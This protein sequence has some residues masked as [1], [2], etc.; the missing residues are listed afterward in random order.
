MKASADYNVIVIMLDSFRQDHIGFYNRGEPVFEGIEPCKTPNIDRFAQESVV[1]ENAYPSGLPTIPLR[2]ELMTGQDT[3]PFRPWQPLTREDIT[4][5]DILRREGY[6]CGL[7]SDTYHYRA[8]GMN[9]HRSFYAYRWMRGQE[10]DPYTSHPSERGVED[11]VNDNYP[12]IWRRRV[13]Q[14]LANTDDFEKEEDWFPAKVVRESIDW[15]RKN[16][17]HKKVFLW[18]DSFDPHEPWDP[19]ERFD[20]YTDPSYEGP[21]LILPMGGFAKEWATEDEIRHIQGLYAGEASF[22][23]HCLGPLFEGLEEL[24]Y[25]D[26]SMI[27]LLAGHGHPLADHGKFLK[28]TDRL[29]SELL[30]LPFIVHMPGEHSGG[31]TEAIVQFPDLLPTIL[32]VLNLESNALSMHG[33]SFVPVLEDETGE[34][35]K[36]IITGYHEGIDRCIRDREWSYIQRPEGEPDELYNLLKDPKERIS[37]IDE[38]PEEAQR[39]SSLFGQYYRRA[40]VR[41]VKG[42]QGRYEVASSSIE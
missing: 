18:I 15:L 26:D 24:G 11:Y 30:K 19:P 41:V 33:E 7:I 5:A 13:E 14:F 29:Y 2:T 40:G 10:Y 17:G 12:K 28:G 31:K 20:T 38:N 35:R 22:V 34:H 23:D 27:V 25:Y 9:F 4:I 1:F 6:I 8:P 36:A 42:V 21:R 37:L 3:L 39:L 16:R 32:D